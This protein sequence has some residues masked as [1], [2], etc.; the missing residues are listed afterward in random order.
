[1]RRDKRHHRRLR[2]ILITTLLLPFQ[3][4]KS[5]GASLAFDSAADTAYDSGWANGSNG[6]YGWGSAWQIANG[7]GYTFIAGSTTN[8][9]ADIDTAGRSWGQSTELPPRSNGGAA[10]TRQ[11]SGELSIGQSF[12][13]NFSNGIV[14]NAPSVIPGASIS[15]SGQFGAAFTFFVNSLS[16]SG[17]YGIEDGLGGN[18]GFGLSLPLTQ[19]LHLVF[20]LTSV[21]NYTFSVY[22][23]GS[24]ALLLT[25]NGFV[26]FPYIQSITNSISEVTL[27]TVNGGLD[28][29]DWNFFNNMAIV[30]EPSALLLV[31]LALPF[32]LLLRRASACT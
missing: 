29:A 3:A 15:L 2:F 30:P 17:G 22:D 11:F 27:E 9:G 13:I 21:T 32:A 28:P 25:T 5:N 4:I 19:G 8:G 23:V 18:G 12:I 6:G 31:G 7:A 16:N 20:T 24:S 26:G 10:A 14:T 1:M